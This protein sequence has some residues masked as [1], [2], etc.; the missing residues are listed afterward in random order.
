MAHKQSLDKI[1]LQQKLFAYAYFNNNGNG[2]K[3]AIEAGYSRKTATEQASRLLTNVKVTNLIDN[4]NE[5][6][7]EK[8]LITKERTINEY[9]YTGLFDIR[10][11]Y[12]ENNALKPISK[13]SNEAARAIAS[14]ETYEVFEG[15]GIDRKH[16]GNTIRVKLNSK[17][18]ALDSIRDAMGWKAINKTANVT[19]DGEDFL[20]YP[21]VITII[22]R[23]NENMPPILDREP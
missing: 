2:S 1:T 23:G 19:K 14:I 21:P 16:V 9:T 20:L 7:E 17:I 12:D 22:Q 5:Q 10:T 13:F 8:V 3:A 15:T 6:V 18:A 4:L 11:L